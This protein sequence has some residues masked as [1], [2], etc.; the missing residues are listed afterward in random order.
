M[1]FKV[2]LNFLVARISRTPCLKHERYLKF[3]WQ[4]WLNTHNHLI[5]KRTLNYLA[6]LP[7][8][9][10]KESLAKWLSV[11]LQTKWL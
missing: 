11:C 7:N 4:Q 5:C 8:L 2:N 1:R 6:K 9:A 10:T 3:K